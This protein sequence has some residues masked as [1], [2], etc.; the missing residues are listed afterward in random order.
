MAEG[1]HRT[2]PDFTKTVQDAHIGAV[3]GE[4][5]VLIS[6]ADGKPELSPAGGKETWLKEKPG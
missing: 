6:G 5:G 1:R 4:S 3:F 2:L